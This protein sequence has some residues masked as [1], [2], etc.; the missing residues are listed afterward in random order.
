[1][2]K[3]SSTLCSRLVYIQESPMRA[4]WWKVSAL[5]GR[6]LH[7][8]TSTQQCV[9]NYIFTMQESFSIWWVTT[10]LPRP[11]GIGSTEWLLNG[12]ESA[13]RI[14]KSQWN[15]CMTFK[16]VID[17]NVHDS[18]NPPSMC[19]I[20]SHM[21]NVITAD[22]AQPRNQSIATSPFERMGSG[23]ETRG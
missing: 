14:L 3:T 11:W 23:H 18:S 4:G 13:V 22:S 12:A 8:E 1:M 7:Q 17:C 15:L 16:H 10:L 2:W 19:T 21:T 5:V 6:V 9:L 20:R